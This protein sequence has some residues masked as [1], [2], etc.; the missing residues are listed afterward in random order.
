[1]F[2][3]LLAAGVRRGELHA[4]PYKMCHMT[5]TSLMLHSD[6]V[7]LFVIK[8]QIKTGNKLQFQH[9]LTYCCV[10]QRSPVG[11]K[12]VP[13]YSYEALF[14]EVGVSEKERSY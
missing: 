9:S 8:T 13:L 2:L 10:E 12:V 1:M 3:V 6:R 4:I 14:H 7:S 5:E 11:H